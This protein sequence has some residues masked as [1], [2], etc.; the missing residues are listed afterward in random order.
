MIGTAN[1]A[2][3]YR[4]AILVVFLCSTSFASAQQP[5]HPMMGGMPD[6]PTVELT[7]KS[8]KNA[9]DAYLLLREKYGDKLPPADEARAMA[10]G[11]KAMADMNAIVT[12][13]GF[14]DAQEWQAAITS[15]AMAS[16]FAEKGNAA[17]FDEKMA[18]MQANPHIPE[19]YKKQ[20]METMKKVRPSENNLKVVTAVRAD[21][22]Y[23]KKIEEIDK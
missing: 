13:K 19:A 21:P 16:G 5:A 9:I 12:E 8:A 11:A 15:V 1:W 3:A 22:E 18:E 6:I 23:G 2:T 4:F 10:E 14:K 20:M 17:E 7:E